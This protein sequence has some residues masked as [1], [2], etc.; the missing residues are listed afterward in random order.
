MTSRA[1]PTLGG[2]RKTRSANSNKSNKKVK[3]T[4]NT[5]VSKTSVKDTLVKAVFC[6]SSTKKCGFCKLCRPP[7]L[8]L[9]GTNGLYS[10]VDP[11]QGTHYIHYFCMLFSS[12]GAQEGGDDDGLLGFLLPS[13]RSELTRSKNR[14]CRYCKKTGASINCHAKGCRTSFHFPCGSKAGCLYQF[15]G[16]YTS[17]CPQHRASQVASLPTIS[18]DQDCV[19]CY[20]PVSLTRQ[21]AAQ[22]RL[23]CP[24]CGRNFHCACLQ[25]M[26]L[27][28]GSLCFKCPHCNN[29]EQFLAGMRLAG[30]YVPDKDADWEGEENSAFYNYGDLYRQAKKCSASDCLAENREEHKL[31][32]KW[33]IILCDF[34]GLNGVHIDCEGLDLH[35]PDFSC[36]D[37]KEPLDRLARQDRV[38]CLAYNVD[39]CVIKLG[40]LPE[41]TP[42]VVIR[43]G[44]R[45]KKELF[46]RI[47]S[48]VSKYRD[49]EGVVQVECLKCKETVPWMFLHNLESHLENCPG[50]EN[51]PSSRYPSY[52]GV[53]RDES[54]GKTSYKCDKCAK[55]F[56]YQT[57]IEKHLKIV[58]GWL[59]T[60]KPSPTPPLRKPSPTPPL[61]QPSPTP[62]PTPSPVA[63]ASTSH[64]SDSEDD[65]SESDTSSSEDDETIRAIIKQSQIPAGSSSAT[66]RKL[67][68]PS[69]R[70]DLTELELDLTMAQFA[71][72]DKYQLVVFI[73]DISQEERR[74][75]FKLWKHLDQQIPTGHSFKCD[76]CENYFCERWQLSS[77]L[78]SS[79][80]QLFNQFFKIIRPSFARLNMLP[81]FHFYKEKVFS[82]VGQEYCL[83][84]GKLQLTRNTLNL[85]DSDAKKSEQGFLQNHLI[86]FHLKKKLLLDCA[87]EPPVYSC[88][89]LNCDS[90]FP[91][92]SPFL[93]HLAKAHC[94]VDKLLQDSSTLSDL[95]GTQPVR[96]Y[97]NPFTQEHHK[98]D[99]CG[100]KAISKA[101]LLIHL[102]EHK[103]TDQRQDLVC[104]AKECD[105]QARFSDM[106]VAR[107]F[108]LK[109]LQLE[110]SDTEVV[111]LESSDDE[112]KESATVNKEF[113]VGIKIIESCS[114]D[115]KEFHGNT[116]EIHKPSAATDIES[117]PTEKEIKPVHKPS[118]KEMKPVVKPF[119]KEMKPTVKPFNKEMKPPAKPF[120][121]EIKPHVKP[122]YKEMKPIAKSFDKETVVKPIHTQVVHLDD[123]DDD[124]TPL[125]IIKFRKVPI[126]LQG[127]FVCPFCTSPY[128]EEATLLAHLVSNHFREKLAFM[129][130]GS[131]SPFACPKTG[132]SFRHKTREGVGDHLGR[133][134]REVVVKLVRKIFPGFS[135]SKHHEGDI[136]ARNKAIVD[137]DEIIIED[138]IIVLGE[139]SKVQNSQFISCEIVA[140]VERSNPDLE[141]SDSA[142]VKARAR[143]VV[144]P[145]GTRVDLANSP[146]ARIAPMLK[147]AMGGQ[148]KTALNK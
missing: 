49:S 37:C 78:S 122:F 113:D 47:S 105:F 86:D 93:K 75:V 134:H 109:H 13:V 2:K 50:D 135:F 67:Y 127:S 96:D 128:R 26:A 76:Q 73:G 90:T 84:C 148:A 97:A 101:S 91:S 8:T 31:G 106:A 54:L 38:T 60:R 115:E 114:I 137:D 18:P 48:R 95:P 4:D 68:K 125:P 9:L 20:E 100:K 102:M 103:Q 7:E 15:M 87:S 56:N 35:K 70:F 72:K 139:T 126:P 130:P 59:N 71:T 92:C 14:I 43:A 42:S 24:G 69:Q 10:M 145:S 88:R 27:A 110:H 51:S 144:L 111:D 133:R 36:V 32:T 61:R 141:T 80:T 55:V 136:S 12:E 62:S 104:P 30:V 33:E 28:S 132:C 116:S 146:H 94:R 142:S 63:E 89:L 82:F 117:V 123:S 23:A 138:E 25:R 81:Q 140:E 17:Y 65:S 21:V 74:V 143:P 118:N 44:E 52:I 66:A 6:P 41:S 58:H 121:K 57:W 85:E 53:T 120:N 107:H 83:L 39:T 112:E 45:G 79:C 1:K 34:C 131:E 98:C 108:G 11:L 22:V 16:S 147:R 64:T 124:D 77:H 40:R 19:V 29:S 3:V 46:N 99:I 129:V 119:N 5:K